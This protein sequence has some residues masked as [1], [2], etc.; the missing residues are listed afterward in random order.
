MDHI[1]GHCSW[2]SLLL[3][4]LTASVSFGDALAEVYA[5]L[6]VQMRDNRY[7]NAEQ[8]LELFPY[9]AYRDER[10]QVDLGNLS[11]RLMEDRPVNFQA[12]ADYG[13]DSIKDND[14]YQVTK[15]DPTLYAGISYTPKFDQFGVVIHALTD[16]TSQHDGYQLRLG[17]THEKMNGRWIFL[18]SVSALYY[19]ARMSSYYFG[20]DTRS[21]SLTIPA[22]KIGNSQ[23]FNFNTTLIYR[24]DKRLSLATQIDYQYLDAVVAQSPIVEDRGTPTLISGFM[25]QF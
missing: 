4:S 20:V 3:L 9:L 23:H 11:Y 15:I 5:G 2:L 8:S 22:H 12:V 21:R 17:L 14:G 10:L 24:L 6:G 7:I 19:S 18:S 13:N 25:Y 16:A 1:R